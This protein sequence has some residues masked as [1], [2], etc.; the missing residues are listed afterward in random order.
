MSDPIAKAAAQIDAAPSSTEP[1]V[2]SEVLDEFKAL[3]EKVEH[4]IHPEA[5]SELQRAEN[6]TVAS[7]QLPAPVLGTQQDAGAVA[8]S[9]DAPAVA[10]PGEPSATL[11]TGDAPS[12]PI[13]SPTSTNTESRGSVTGVTTASGEPKVGLHNPAA[14][15]RGHIAAIKQHLSLRGFEQSAVAD[16]HAELDKIEGWL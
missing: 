2:F 6:P 14:A 7:G 13:A 12:A 1:S 5:A 8:A 9:T 3:G 16:I 4:L 10:Q 15:I 11:P